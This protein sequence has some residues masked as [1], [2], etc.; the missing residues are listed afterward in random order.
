MVPVKGLR[1]IALVHAANYRRFVALGHNE[2]KRNKTSNETKVRTRGVLAG[3]D[4]VRGTSAR[5]RTRDLPPFNP[6][7]D[8]GTWVGTES[9]TT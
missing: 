2:T 4:S 7:P 6:M 8:P 3:A 5:P 9:A 1:G